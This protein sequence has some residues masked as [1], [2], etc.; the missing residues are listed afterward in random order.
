MSS[1]YISWCK[2]TNT[3][4]ATAIVLQ[5]VSQIGYSDGTVVGHLKDFGKVSVIGHKGEGPD[6]YIVLCSFDEEAAT[7]LLPSVVVVSP[8]ITWPIHKVINDDGTDAKEDGPYMSDEEFDKLIK[9]PDE[10]FQKL[11]DSFLAAHKQQDYLKKL[12]S[13][14]KDSKGEEGLPPTTTSSVPP[15]VPPVVT[16]VPP[17]VPPVIPPVVSSVGTFSMPPVAPSTVSW[18]L[19]PFIPSVVTPS[20]PP[21]VEQ[22]IRHV[23]ETPEHHQP[24]RLRQFS[25]KVPVPNGEWDFD[26]WEQM[27]RQ[28]V[29]SNDHMS[30]MAKKRRLTDSLMPPAL[31]FATDPVYHTADDILEALT[32]AYGLVCDGED[33]YTQF[34]DTYQEPREKPSDFLVRLNSLLGKVVQRGGVSLARVNRVRLDQLIRGCLYNEGILSELSLSGKRDSPPPYAD[35]LQ[36]IRGEEARKEEKER[37]RRTAKKELV[38]AAEQTVDSSKEKLEAEVAQLRSQL[39]KSCVQQTPVSATAPSP[40]GSNYRSKPG[41]PSRRRKVFCY[42]CGQD[43]HFLKDCSQPANADLVQQKLLERATKVSGNE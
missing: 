1:S 24:R 5:G 32:K 13:S 20:L 38:K 40:R 3:D 43:G 16:A 30:L 14:S 15:V 29:L 10:E 25:G 12:M 8:D 6:T 41:Q 17:V 26:T 27:A 35:L 7:F 23:V 42:K 2:E 36:L 31:A 34:R 11:L 18:S 33:L 19:P 37:R 28:T 22:V 9:A 39:A 4:P 21:A